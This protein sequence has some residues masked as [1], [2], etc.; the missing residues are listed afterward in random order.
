MN[1]IEKAIF[2]QTVKSVTEREPSLL[3]PIVDMAVEGVKVFAEHQSDIVTQA[4]FKLL[5]ILD[6]IDPPKDGKFGSFTVD[7][8]VNA[9]S[10]FEGTPALDELRKK[11]GVTKEE[12]DD[13][14]KGS[15]DGWVKKGWQ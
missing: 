13:K 14:P 4:Q 1:E 5:C 8:I 9:L 2:L 10:C 7:S 6:Q 12:P 15:K 11:Y 3:R